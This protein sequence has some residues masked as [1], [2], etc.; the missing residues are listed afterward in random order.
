MILTL[1]LQC[2]K[3][4]R[5]SKY[6][7]QNR[8]VERSTVETLEILVPEMHVCCVYDTKKMGVKVFL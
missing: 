7:R 5:S 2:Q 6:I 8:Y 3:L 1:N 4:Q